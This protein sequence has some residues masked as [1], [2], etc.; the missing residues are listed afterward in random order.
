MIERSARLGFA[1]AT[2]R[3]LPYSV[4]FILTH[5]CNFQCDYCD[6]PAAAGAEMSKDEFC[7]AIDELAGAGMARASFS[8]G[9][10]LLRPDA[11]AIVGHAKSRGLFTSLNTNGWLVGR[12]IDALASTLDMMVVS[13]DGPEDRHDLVRRKRGSYKRVLGAIDLARSRGVAVATITVLSRQNLSVVDDVLALAENHGFWAY[14][15]PAYAD[16]FEHARGLDSALSPD[17]LA[18]LARDLGRARARGLPVAASPGFLER[19]GRGPAFGDCGDCH[20]GR[21]FGTVLP[22]G[23]VVPCHLVSKE[24][25]YPNGREIGFVRAF[26]EMPHPTR[27]PGCAISPYQESDLIF[28]LDT[29]AIAAAIERF[30]RTPG[31]RAHS[32]G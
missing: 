21:Y 17:V 12:H 27:G 31:P 15:Q 10:V 6:I 7:A 2:R 24:A 28:H 11:L 1:L 14:F 9:E 30:S 32:R 16:C 18:A 25:V 4:T 5:R 23:V 8:G 26:L 20:A 29:R 3:R 19:L 22:D 13:I